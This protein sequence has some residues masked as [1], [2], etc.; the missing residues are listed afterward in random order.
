MGAFPEETVLRYA[1]AIEGHAD[2]VTAA[3]LGGLVVTLVSA[4]GSVSAVK[5]RWPKL[6]RVVAITPEMS[7]E[8]SASRAV[9]P[10]SVERVDAVYNLQR[11]VLFIAAIEERFRARLIPG[12]C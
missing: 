8:T 1:A 6:L 5:K 3:L 4:D 12:V 10:K 11:A 9:L 2:N 7:L